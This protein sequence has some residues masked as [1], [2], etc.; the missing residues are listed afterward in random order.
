[1][2]LQSSVMRSV[3][4][5][6]LCSKPVTSSSSSSSSL[7]CR[8]LRDLCYTFVVVVVASA[9][10]TYHLGR[11]L[12]PSPRH[13][14]DHHD[15][16]EHDDPDHQRALPRYRRRTADTGTDTDTSVNVRQVLEGLGIDRTRWNDNDDDLD[17]TYKQVAECITV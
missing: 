14:H 7:S 17:S 4:Q 1:M 8:R 9:L 10:L 11:Q 3:V 6:L 5:R 16:H 12:P 15:H 13:H 2:Q